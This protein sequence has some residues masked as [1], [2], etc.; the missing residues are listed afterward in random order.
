V[1]I[2]EIH[3]EFATRFFQWAHHRCPLLEVLIW[4]TYEEN[5][6]QEAWQVTEDAKQGRDTSDCGVDRAPQQCFVKKLV[7][8]EDG[9]SQI[10]GASRVTRSRI[11]HDFPELQILSYETGR[12]IETRLADEAVR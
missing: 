6:H 8:L 2:C 10:A 1:H 4:G 3:Q 9:T 7:E 5:F 11:R 12:H